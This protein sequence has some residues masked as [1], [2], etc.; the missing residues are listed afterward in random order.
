M[1]RLLENYP[2]G[3]LTVVETGRESQPER[4]LDGVRYI[5]KPLAQTR[6]MN[7][8]FHPYMVAFFS[9]AAKKAQHVIAT[10]NNVEFDS[11]LTVAHGFGWLAAARLAETRGVPLHLIVHDDWPRVANVPSSFRQWLDECFATVYRQAKTRMC[12]SPSMRDSYFERYGGEAHLLYPTRAD[13]CPDFTAPPVRLGKNTDR[14][15]V[16]FAGSINTP[17]YVEALRA[18]HASLEPVGG[19]LLVFGPLTSSE[20]SDAGLNLTNIVLCGFVNW[21]DLIKRL[22]EEVDALFVPMSFTK[23][24]R[25]NMELACP[26]KLAD[27]TAVG[28]PLLIYGPDYCSAVRWAKENPGASEVV[29]TEG[30]VELANAVQRLASSPSNRVLLGMRALEVGRRDFSSNLVRDV[31]NHALLSPDKQTIMKPSTV[32]CSAP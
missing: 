26:S 31:F 18:L 25:L 17:G 22:R 1:Y 29:T 32:L 20:A 11:V 2:P 27:Y 28:L 3:H 5:Y 24:D 10:L 15:T 23:A 16:A 19:R 21:T 12:V 7:T 4:R 13:R 9:R 14:L 30:S 8:R 6:W